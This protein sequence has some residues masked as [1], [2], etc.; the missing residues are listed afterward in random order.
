MFYSKKKP[1]QLRKQLVC[2]K[3][4]IG[5]KSQ[6]SKLITD[7]GNEKIIV[8]TQEEGNKACTAI[9][10]TDSQEWIK[11]NEDQRLGALGGELI[12]LFVSFIT[13]FFIQTL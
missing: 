2:Q 12:R 6:C 3:R 5:Y 4:R 7:D 13:S 10:D 11:L 8:A 9:F 1:I